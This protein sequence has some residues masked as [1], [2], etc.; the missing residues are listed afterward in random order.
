[1]ISKKKLVVILLIVIGFIIALVIMIIFKSSPYSRPIT[2]SYSG[3]ALIDFQVKAVLNKDNFDYDHVDNNGHQIRFRD[4]D[5]ATDLSFWREKWKEGNNQESIFWVKV[6]QIPDKGKI[7]YLY[8]KS[9]KYKSP[10]WDDAS[11]MWDN[12]KHLNI[13]GGVFDYNASWGKN[14]SHSREMQHRLG[15]AVTGLTALLKSNGNVNN[16]GED[17]FDYGL[18]EDYN[19]GDAI[20]VAAGYTHVCVL[21]LDGNVD[22]YGNDDYGEAEDYNGGDAIGVA[23][24][25]RH[26]CILK[27][28]GNVDCYGDNYEGQADDYNGGDAI[29]VAAGYF[30]TCVL[31]SNGNVDCWGKWW[32]FDEGP[33]DYFGGDAIGV[34]AGYR[35]I[36]VLKL[37]GNVDCWG[38]NR[39]GQAEDYFRGDAIGVAV[40]ENHTCVLRANGN[41]DCYGRNDYRDRYGESGRGQAEDYNDGDAIGVAAG[42]AYTCIF[43]ANGNVDCYGKNDYGKA[44]DYNGGDVKNPFRKYALPEPATNIGNEKADLRLGFLEFF[45]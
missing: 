9:P 28:N 30:H 34:A 40:G 20:G 36:C 25:S 32:Q 2:I 33:E 11:K 14:A 42:Y 1:M 7:I 10:K 44:E 43:K 24:G 19:G 8:Y 27:S 39:Y 12:I 21:K 37:D 23:A 6:P 45:R 3:E 4:T 35:H 18:A 17:L 15:I 13:F 38:K 16:H 29:G 31:K 5:K 26:T 22:C 41:V